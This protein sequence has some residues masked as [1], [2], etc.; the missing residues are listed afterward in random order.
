MLWVL[1]IAA[2]IRVQV[3]GLFCI[4]STLFTTLGLCRCAAALVHG[5]KRSLLPGHAW[6]SG[7][8]CDLQYQ[9]YLL[10]HMTASSEVSYAVHGYKVL[11]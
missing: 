5:M 4:P 6:L 1:L 2:G 8:T 7:P 9:S 10:C 11:T 3:Y